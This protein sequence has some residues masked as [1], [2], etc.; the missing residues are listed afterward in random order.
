M[1][2]MAKAMAA[3]GGINNDHDGTAAF[4]KMNKKMS[5][6]TG[7]H[8]INSVA[9]EFISFTF[10]LLAFGSWDEQCEWIQNTRAIATN[11]LYDTMGNDKCSVFIH[12]GL[13]S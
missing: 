10:Y 2:T 8:V 12:H 3:G 9:T 6:S 1:T 7:Q 4:H 5:A 13:I 11:M